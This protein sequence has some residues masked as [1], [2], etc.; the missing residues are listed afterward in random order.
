M[1]DLKIK[2][3]KQLKK[4]RG[5]KTQRAFA[6]EIGID[7]ATLN[8]IEQ[9]AENITLKTIQKMTN[10]LKCTVGYLFGE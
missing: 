9:K 3:A 1:A 4:L 6:K 5:D 2:L 7:V 8:R 10:S